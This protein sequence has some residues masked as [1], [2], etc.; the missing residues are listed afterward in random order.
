MFLCSIKTEIVAQFITKNLRYFLYFP[1][2]K[3]LVNSIKKYK[4]FFIFFQNRHSS[5]LYKKVFIS[6]KTEIL[7]KFLKN[8]KMFLYLPKQKFLK[9]L[10]SI[11]TEISKNNLYLLKT[12]IYKHQFYIFIQKKSCMRLPAKNIS[13]SFFRIW[14]YF[15]IFQNDF[16]YTQPAFFNLL[17]QNFLLQNHQKKFLDHH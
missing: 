9:K 2:A 13:K 14:F 16:S 4:N 8:P 6:L 11:K 1:K 7:V 3:I 10:Y 12:E 15:S 5:T 17:Y